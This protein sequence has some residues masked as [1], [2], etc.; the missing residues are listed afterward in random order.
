MKTS[1]GVGIFHL[2]AW[3]AKHLKDRKVQDLFKEGLTEWSL[4]RKLMTL[5]R[6]SRKKDRKKKGPCPKDQVEVPI[7]IEDAKFPIGHGVFFLQFDPLGPGPQGTS[8]KGASLQPTWRRLGFG[9]LELVLERMNEL[10]RTHAGYP[11]GAKGKNGWI[12]PEF[13]E[14]RPDGGKD[15][16]FYEGTF[17]LPAWDSF[18]LSDSCRAGEVSAGEFD[19]FLQ[20]ILRRLTDGDLEERVS[21]GVDHRLRLVALSVHA[22]DGTLHVHPVFLKTEVLAYQKGDGRLLPAGHEEIPGGGRRKKGEGWV[23]GSRLGRIGSDGKLVTNP[24]GPAGCSASALREAKIPPGIQHGDNWDL[25]EMMLKSRSGA[26]PDGKP[27]KIKGQEGRAREDKLGEPY[28]NFGC[29]VLRQAIRDLADRNAKFRERREKLIADAIEKQSKENRKLA[30]IVAKPEILRLVA[31]IKKQ[32]KELK[33]MHEQLILPPSNQA[34]PSGD[35]VNEGLN[36]T[37]GVVRYNPEVLERWLTAANH[38]L[39][40]GSD[41]STMSPE[42]RQ[43]VEIKPSMG[44]SGGR[45]GLTARALGFVLRAIAELEVVVRD[46][47]ATEPDIKDANPRGLA[48]WAVIDLNDISMGLSRVE[49]GRLVQPGPFFDPEKLEKWLTEASALVAANKDLSSM[50]LEAREA[51]EIKPSP[52]CLRVGLTKRAFRF[53]QSAIRELETSLNDP[54][55]TP[56]TKKDSTHRLSQFRSVLSDAEFYMGIKGTAKNGNERDLRK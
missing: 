16:R 6:R 13:F 3:L 23:G 20:A 55:S 48:F 17:T 24:L 54:I 51:V 27:S 11:S 46:P 33:T 2:L 35:N 25:H 39:W 15:M 4:G 56:A 22:M 37:P 45:V 26:A 30:H 1:G 53:V 52:A 47:K 38:L 28:D 40:L 34:G 44:K 10:G 14:V 8:P 31:I 12:K 32:K 49:D 50:S 41:L 29:G 5:Y 19:E 9:D 42:A 36:P 18:A 43:A 7:N 21:C